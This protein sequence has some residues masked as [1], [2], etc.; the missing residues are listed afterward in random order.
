GEAVEFR[1]RRA[2][3][4]KR[5]EIA[6]ERTAAGREGPERIVAHALSPS[7]G[8]PPGSAWD[9]LARDEEGSG[10]SSRRIVDGDG[11]LGARALD[12]HFPLDRRV[13]ALAVQQA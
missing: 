3:A 9:R 11:R 13:L 10:A 12:H 4:R 5:R 8:P 1:V 6:A 7:A 2:A